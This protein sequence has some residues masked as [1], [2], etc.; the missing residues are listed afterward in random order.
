MREFIKTQKLNGKLN[1]E[2]RYSFENVRGEYQYD[3]FSNKN[4]TGKF[5]VQNIPVEFLNEFDKNENFT[6]AGDG[7]FVKGKI[8]GSSI[9]GKPD[10]LSFSVEETT[11]QIVW[12][13]DEQRKLEMSYYIPY[14]SKLA[15]NIKASWGYS[16][17]Y[18][19]KFISNEFKLLVKN[20]EIKFNENISLVKHEKPDSI[21]HRLLFPMITIDIAK[22]E[23]IYKLLDNYKELMEQ[24]MLVLSFILFHRLNCFGFEARIFDENNKVIHTIDH[25]YTKKKSGIDCLLEDKLEFNN[26]FNTDNVSKII[27]SFLALNEEHKQKFIRV[28]YS[29]LTIKELDIFEPK[30]KDTFYALEAISKIIVNPMTRI[31]PEKLI[32]NACD[33]AEIDLESFDFLPSNNSNEL[34]WLI[35]EYRNDLTHF[36]FNIKFDLSELFNERNKMMRLLRSLMMYYLT[37][38]LKEFPFPGKSLK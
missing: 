35:S 22:D 20:I 9:F 29:Y 26:Y 34:K 31:S 5:E 10:T 2:D 13:G 15:R 23:D 12:E 25:R 30:F 3:V 1:V 14:V 37:P 28:I 38:E 7:F 8:T 19:V 18:I 11:S 24:V 33:I 21:F 27:E 4:M 36:N 6:F 16:E 17:E 32:I